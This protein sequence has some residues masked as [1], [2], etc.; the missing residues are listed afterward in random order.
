M[1]LC[2]QPIGSNPICGDGIIL[3]TYLETSSGGTVGGG[4]I[5]RQ[6]VSANSIG[7]FLYDSFWDSPNDLNQHEA[8]TGQTWNS[9]PTYFEIEEGGFVN[10]IETGPIFATINSGQSNL[11]LGSTFTLDAVSP[12]YIGVVFRYLNATNYWVVQYEQPNAAFRILEI[13]GG[14]SSQFA[15]AVLSLDYGTPYTLNVYANGGT[16][17][18]DL[19]GTEISTTDA[20]SF[21]TSTTVGLF[22]NSFPGLGTGF[23]NFQATLPAFFN[24]A[25][26]GGLAGGGAIYNQVML[27]V[28]DGGTL[29]GGQ[30][31]YDVNGVEYYFPPSS[32]GALGSGAASPLQELYNYPSGGTLGNSSA[33]P[34]ATYTPTS[35]GGTLGGGS[36][37]VSHFFTVPVGGGG[38]AS[39]NAITTEVI[40]YLGT[41][42]ITVQAIADLTGFPLVFTFRIPSV[43]VKRIQATDDDENI[44]PTELVA[45]VEG[46][47]WAVVRTNLSSTEETVIT[48]QYGNH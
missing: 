24:T 14:L 34:E 31:D 37:I 20:T 23:T 6:Y 17:I 27:D 32:G 43:L 46:Q 21:L 19:A 39:G 38:L 26:G 28:S 47:T 2:G 1:A 35:N 42:T 18:A 15:Y 5:L 7:T 44:L 45:A 33:L 22:L 30:L 9:S 3:A 25:S 4:A 40:G 36:A 16:I 13:T 48:L 8:D 11:S 41:K 12:G 29:C 10:T